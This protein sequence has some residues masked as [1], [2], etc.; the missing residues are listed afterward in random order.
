[1]IRVY[2]SR[3]L[4]DIQIE[5]MVYADTAQQAFDVLHDTDFSDFATKYSDPLDFEKVI[6]KSMLATKHDLTKLLPDPLIFEGVWKWYDFYNMKIAM[7]AVVL[8]RDFEVIDQAF[9]PYG[10]FSYEEIRMCAY[11]EKTIEIFTGLQK[12][13]QELYSTTKNARYI[14][15]V[16][17]KALYLYL[18]KWSEQISS[19]IIRNYIL[20][21]V[22]FHNIQSFFRMSD[23]ERSEYSTWVYVEGGNVSRSDFQSQEMMERRASQMFSSNTME[24]FKSDNYFQGLHQEAEKLLFS[25]IAETR[26]VP[27]GPEP[28]WGYWL[29]RKNAGAVIR[30]IMVGKLNQLSS[31][32]IQKNIQ[33]FLNK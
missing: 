5:R 1:M 14:D 10:S 6:E 8:G 22:D 24:T 26:Y 21:K 20:K 11:G 3:L 28:I 32:E 2:E 33:L 17:D 27:M 9:S 29:A 30:M 12:E 18:L 16:Y 7:K 13:A 15:F 4:S 31:E 23:D 19:E 25:F